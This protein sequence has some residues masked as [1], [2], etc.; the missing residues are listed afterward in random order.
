MH[1]SQIPASLRALLFAAIFAFPSASPAAAATPTDK[2]TTTP[3]LLQQGFGP[4]GQILP[5]DGENY[6]APTSNANSLLWLHNN[7]FDRLFEQPFESREDNEANLVLAIGGAMRTDAQGGTVL[8]QIADGV[9]QYLQLKGYGGFTVTPKFVGDDAGTTPEDLTLEYLQQANDDFAYMNISVNWGQRTASGDTFLGGHALT[10]LRADPALD[11]IILNNPAPFVAGDN[12]EEFSTERVDFEVDGEI[13]NYLNL[14]LTP[15]GQ[16][17]IFALLYDTTLVQSNTDDPATTAVADP[18]ELVGTDGDDEA[19]NGIINTNGAF[20][21]VEAPL[22]GSGRL[23]KTD[24]D[25]FEGTLVLPEGA[26]GGFDNPY[27]F[28]GGLFVDAGTLRLEENEGNPAGTGDTELAGGELV[29]APAGSGLDPSLAL[30]GGTGDTFTYSGGG[31]LVLESGDHDRLTVTLGGNT[32]GSTPNFLR[33]EFEEL[34][35]TGT[36]TIVPDLG[37]DALGHEERLLV[38]GTGTNLPALT[39]GIVGPE[40]IVADPL[41]QYDGSFTTYDAST[42]FLPEPGTPVSTTPLADANANALVDLDLDQTLAAGSTAEVYGV[43]VGEGRTLAG[44]TGAT[45]QLGAG[46]A[47]TESGLILNGGTVSVP[48]LDWRASVGH[49]YTGS[50]GAR[51]DSTLAGTSQGGLIVFGPGRLS[52]T[53]ANTYEG[54]TV[55]LDGFVSADNPATG[56]GSAT[57]TNLVLVSR[58]GLLAGTG[59]VGGSVDLNGIL[60]PGSVDNEGRHDPS[61]STATQILSIDGQLVLRED[62]ILAWNLMRLADG[63][64]GGVAGQDWTAVQVGTEFAAEPSSYLQLTFPTGQD[65]ESG[66]PFWRKERSWGILRYGSLTALGNLSVIGNNLQYGNFQLLDA[67]ASSAVALLYEP[68]GGVIPIFVPAGEEYTVTTE[69]GER[70][71]LP[72]EVSGTGDLRLDGLGTFAVHDPFALTGEVRLAGDATL[73]LYATDSLATPAAVTTEGTSTLRFEADQ[74]MRALTLG[75]GTTLATGGHDLTVEGRLDAAGTLEGSG[76][77]GLEGDR[78]HSITGTSRNYTGT[79]AVNA[80]SLALNG[81]LGDAAGATAGLRMGPGTTLSGTGTFL[82]TATLTRGS[83]HEPGNSIGTQTFSHYELHDGA[84]L[85]LEFGWNGSAFVHDQVVFTGSATVGQSGGDRPTLALSGLPGDFFYN[86]SERF[87]VLAGEPGA[88]L[89]VEDLPAVTGAPR[90]P[91][92]S[93]VPRV[94]GNDLQVVATRTQYDAVPGAGLAAPEATTAAVFDR[95]VDTVPTGSRSTTATFLRGLD[96]LGQAVLDGRTGAASAYQQAW[97]QLSGERLLAVGRSHLRATHAW[98]TQLSDLLAGRGHG[99]TD[100]L[101]AAADLRPETLLAEVDPQTGQPT[102]APATGPAPLAAASSPWRARAEVLGA[103][104]A[105]DTVDGISGYEADLYGVLALLDYPV[106]PG[107]RLGAT[108]AYSSHRANFDQYGGHA[109][110][111]T[112]RLGPTLHLFA[113]RPYSLTAAATVGHTRIDTRRPVSLNA[114]T[115]SGDTHGWDTTLQV[116]GTYPLAA[117][118]RWQL[119]ALGGLRWIDFQRDAFSETGAGIASLQDIEDRRSES[120]LSTLGLRLR[121]TFRRET[122]AWTPSGLVA[123]QHEFLADDNAFRAAFAP[124]EGGSFPFALQP[125]DRD[126]DSLLLGAGVH[127]RFSPHLSL[128]AAYRGSLAH[129]ATS[130]TAALGAEWRF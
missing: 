25:L 49:I 55:I 44:G 106:L 129:D 89:T 97:G 90:V 30:A 116:D 92:V 112:L 58:N 98:S 124:P 126:R 18:W 130:H 40:V 3:A 120:L 111:E 7:G 26:N 50:R 48:T 37:P 24:A 57:G 108:V 5:G 12:P 119:D 93:F 84:T 64:S 101:A 54:G 2:V 71:N 60:V 29:F 70:D 16:P 8:Q 13:G 32:D 21:T 121:Q 33:G 1:F 52:L 127:A 96:G 66:H 72:A 19:T 88:A 125:A 45:L 17:D 42:G 27:D 53:G 113:D 34:G 46:T 41:S 14:D 118:P 4:G 114:S 73:E 105:D 107:T 11:R 68:N 122:V 102:L 82:G 79:V 95:I 104:I 56:G 75:A 20:L 87:S 31:L 78:A 35:P 9:E 38:A 109:D 15:Y 83:R 103:R 28:T 123:W 115:A 67:G 117:S 128:H 59:R 74:R 61:A 62:A 100:R 99:S 81:T 47:G 69:A 85:A 86:G 65:P 63:T 76:D 51:I 110:L 43:R 94:R 6:C 91:L 23:F 22:T 39:H 80:G 77:I 10:L 36:L